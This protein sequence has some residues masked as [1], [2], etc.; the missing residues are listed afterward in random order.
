MTISEYW[1]ANA[2]E[3]CEELHLWSD[4]SEWS[5]V[6]HN[7]GL[8]LLSPGVSLS[9]MVAYLGYIGPDYCDLSQRDDSE[10]DL[11]KTL[12]ACDIDAADIASL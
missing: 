4:Q 5:I 3:G 12:T 6:K 2:G 8:T 1:E 9:A 7:H 10:E 11:E